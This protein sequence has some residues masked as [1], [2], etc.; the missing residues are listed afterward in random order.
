[1][2]IAFSSTVV[3]IAAGV[4]AYLLTLVREDWTRRDLDALRL[5]ADR[6]LQGEETGA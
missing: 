1:M 5:E 6:L 3:G 4:V 2:V